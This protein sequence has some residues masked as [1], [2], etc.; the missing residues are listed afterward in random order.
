MVVVAKAAAWQQR[1]GRVMSFHEK[2]KEISV[3]VSE[4][5]RD[6]CISFSYN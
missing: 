3:L 6:F 2:E 5:E 4:R 1:G